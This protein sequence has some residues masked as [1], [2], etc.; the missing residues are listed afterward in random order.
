VLAIVCAASAGHDLLALVSQT[1]AISCNPALSLRHLIFEEIRDR[2][3][4]FAT[5]PLQAPSV[6]NWG[7]FESGFHIRNYRERQHW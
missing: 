2:R 3:T 1:S 6:A 5:V 7:P 4:A